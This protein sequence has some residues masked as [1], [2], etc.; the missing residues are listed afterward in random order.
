MWISVYG[1][2]HLVDDM[3]NRRMANLAIPPVNVHECDVGTKR[4]SERTSPRPNR[5]VGKGIKI[6]II[7]DSNGPEPHAW[8]IYLFGAVQGMRQIVH[9]GRGQQGREWSLDNILAIA[10]PETVHIPI[11]PSRFQSFKQLR[12]GFSPSL[13][14]TAS[15]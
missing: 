11:V 1:G 13:V 14:L 12:K 3:R 2:Y 7:S 4:A 8:L 5:I 6:Q 15:A 9:V 10:K